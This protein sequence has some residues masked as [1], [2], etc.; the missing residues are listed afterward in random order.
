MDGFQILSTQTMI[1]VHHQPKT[2]AADRLSQLVS[3]SVG[4]TVGDKDR[5]RGIGLTGS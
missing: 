2:A 1:Y 4:D 5:R 3:R